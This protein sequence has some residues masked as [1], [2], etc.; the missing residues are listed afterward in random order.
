MKA[1]RLRAGQVVCPF[2]TLIVLTDVD[3]EGDNTRLT[4][5]VIRSGGE[6]RVTKLYDVHP[7]SDIALCTWEGTEKEGKCKAEVE[8]EDVYRRLCRADVPCTMTVES[9]ALQ[10]TAMVRITAKTVYDDAF[11]GYWT[12]WNV[13]RKTT[14]FDGITSRGL[15][16]GRKKMMAKLTRQAFADAVSSACWMPEREA[17]KAYEE[18]TRSC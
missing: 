1:K 4:G 7:D 10:T 18:A 5:R 15:L 17:Q 12:T 9:T 16:R 3:T 8:A 13:G 2:A 11:T 14:S 6:G